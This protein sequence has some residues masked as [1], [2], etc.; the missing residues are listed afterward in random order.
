M[1]SV[2]PGDLLGL[3]EVFGVSEG[4]TAWGVVVL[5]PALGDV[6]VGLV[7]VNGG[8]VCLGDVEP[9]CVCAGITS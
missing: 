1:F 8:D 3:L 4:V 6:T 7:E 9:N 5:F 2:P